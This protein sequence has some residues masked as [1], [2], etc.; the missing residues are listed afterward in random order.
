VKVNAEA[1]TT[2]ARLL[3][4]ALDM[5]PDERVRWLDD[6]PTEHDSLK[7]RLRQLLRHALTLEGSHFL[8]GIPSLEPGTSEESDAG[9][10]PGEIVGPYRLVRLLA[11]GGMGAVW[12]AE[13][14]DGL[15]ANRSYALKR[16]RRI[17]RRAGLVE[18]MA[19][20]REL[21]ASL[22]HPHIARLY[23]AGLDASGHPYLALEYVEGE[24]I[25]EYC[26]S[27]RLDLRARL[28]LFLQVAD[29]VSYAHAKLIVHRD[30]KPANILVG[31]DGQVKLLDF[32]IAKLLADAESDGTS[33]TELSG[34][35]LTPDYASPEQIAGEPLGTASDVYSLGIV[36]FELLT[37][38][39]PYTLQR[40]PRSALVPAIQQIEPV[41]PSTASELP[42]RAALRGDL[43]TIVLKALK[44]AQD[45]R[46]PTVAAFADDLDRWLA[47]LPIRARPDSVSYRLRRFVRRNALAVSASVAI[48]AAVA[49]GGAVAVWQARVALTEKQRA[50]EVK[51]FIAGIFQDAD[52][53]AGQGRTVSAVDLLRRAK[54]EIDRIG[55]SRPDLRVELLTIVGSSL[56]SLGDID[57]SHAV[58][59][60]AVDEGTSRL[61]ADHAQTIQARLLLTDVYRYRGLVKEMREELARLMPTVRAAEDVRPVDLVRVLE[62]QA[63]MAIDAAEYKDAQSTAKEAYD[64]ATRVLGKRHARTA[65]VA[66]VL[67]ES[68]LYGAMP[69][70]QRMDVIEP[71]YN[72]VLETYADRPRHPRVIYMRDVKARAFFTVGQI[73]HAIAEGEQALR[74]GIEVL[75]PSNLT[76]A[77]FA[78][79]LAGLQR[80]SGDLK[81]S[82]RH[83]NMAIEILDRHSERE[84]YNYAG[85]RLTRG[86]TWLAARR[87]DEARRDL[88]EAKNVLDKIYGPANW[89]ALS[90][91][92]NGAMALAHLGRRAEAERALAPVYDQ[93]PA[94]INK[95][96]AQHVVGIVKRLGGEFA[97][98]LRAQEAAFALIPNDPKADWN[99]ERVLHEIGLNQVEL[100]QHRAALMTFERARALY[101]SRPA[102]MH[103]DRA[104]VLVG[105][106][107]AHIELGDVTAALPLLQESD[108]FW[109]GFDE[110]N[111]SAG[112]AALWLG[113][114]LVLAGQRREAGPVLLH[115]VEI[116]SA[117]PRGAALARLGCE[118]VSSV[119]RGAGAGPFPSLVA[120]CGR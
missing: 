56:V 83:S 119:P 17:W 73:A 14:V 115:A 27:R 103:P 82:I 114:S 51:S 64:L 58:A 96:W 90:A 80:I 39:R 66:T 53:F 76:V 34:P 6:I 37:G 13:R 48:L 57:T 42:W 91:Q 117:S 102:A 95:M 52:P 26:R 110:K 29:A 11:E 88:S 24:P 21:L 46:Y 86:V 109:R 12:L 98:A 59:R 36:L 63:H 61:G 35:P 54:E 22:T 118:W 74:D 55:E 112:E 92:L 25:D 45:D 19:R 49:V 100:G 43:D 60:Q 113:R 65:A 104:E 62:N 7:P 84:S 68:H 15:M 10:R 116:L 32:G 120:P 5:P 47:A 2:L 97:E 44:K 75:G 67:A 107:R 1:W 111:H 9:G 23:D 33:L 38:S 40:Q 28:R 70:Q 69:D 89:E 94:V 72:L 77:Q 31:S 41:A 16:P 30:L 78:N 3:D 71:A 4:A 101:A 106:G 93:S 87:A 79:N 8:E 85:P 81:A 18:R 50:E 108:A 99:R 20:E 105:R